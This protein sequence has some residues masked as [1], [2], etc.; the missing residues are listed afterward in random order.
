MLNKS[1]GNMYDWT[2]YTWNP[3]KG[4]KHNCSYCYVKALAERYGYDLE[5]RFDEKY[6]S[7]KLG[8]GRTIFVGSTTDLFGNW[9]P[10]SWIKSILSYTRKWDNTYLFQTKNPMRFFEYIQLF[11]PKTILATT[12]E[13]DID[14]LV[15]N[16]PG[17]SIRAE[18][19]I[20]LPKTFEKV[21]S[22][23]PIMDF[24]IDILIWWIKAIKPSFVSIGADSKNHHLHEPS[25]EKVRALIRELSKITTVKVKNNLERIL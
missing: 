2:D 21:I 12:I 16:A 7:D 22:I 15:S 24:H 3:V 20:D 23:E 17:P 18:A 6:L 4:C 8:K 13:S 14:Y 25:K 10:D 5:P 1:A 9:V 19:M 11:P